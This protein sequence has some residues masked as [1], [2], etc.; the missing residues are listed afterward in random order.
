MSTLEGK[1]EWILPKAVP[2]GHKKLYSNYKYKEI[3]GTILFNRHIKSKKNLSTYFAS[4]EKVSPSFKQMFDAE[5][6]AKKII[7]AVKEGKKIYIYGDFDADG[8]SASAILWDFLYRE[9]PKLLDF[10][11][12]TSKNG[13]ILPYI[14]QRD[15]GYGLS[16]EALNK[17]QENGADLII[18]V[19]CGI[20]DVELITKFVEKGLDFIVT[21]HHVPSENLPHA[22]PY[23][24]VHPMYPGHEFTYETICGATVAYYLVQAILAQ[25]LDFSEVFKQS[26]KYLDLVALATVTDIMPL[27]GLNRALVQEGLKLV[28]KGRRLGMKTLIQISGG[29][30]GTIESYHLGFLI[31]PRI[32]AAGR[33]GSAM[34]A[35]RLLVTEDDEQARKLSVKLN[36]LNKERQALTTKLLKQSYS[37]VNKDWSPNQK[38]VFVV[39]KG[40]KEGIVGLVAGKL[41][42]EYN[43]PTFVITQITTKTGTEI[44]GSARS[45]R[46]FDITEAIGKCKGYLVRYGGHKQAAGFTVK[47]D[48]LDDFRD[49]ITKEAE[50]QIDKKMLAKKIQL[51]AIVETTELTLDLVNSLEMLKPFGYGNRRPRLLLRD[52]VVVEKKPMGSDKQNPKHMKLLFKGDS[53]GISEAIMF[54]CSEDFGRIE[55]DDVLD[56][57]GFLDINEWNGVTSV[58][59]KVTEWRKA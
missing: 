8:V 55:E 20:R 40:W 11:Q 16:E 14:P 34:D 28:N 36:N 26:N 4:L 45:I 25:V 22:L 24:I 33:I 15:D 57:V 23:T 6:A 1:S 18:T 9:M 43:R 35:L 49:A 10:R 51:D 30:L 56:L 27:D 37:Q 47:S 58:Q 19:D 41:Q 52:I 29:V 50:L 39:G 17:L 12:V 38:L 44:R 42:E 31:G 53:I 48:K 5:G 54:N 21:D 7:N 13:S 2:A 59:F 46:G 32:N 3:I